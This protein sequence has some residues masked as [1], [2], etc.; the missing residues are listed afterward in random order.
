MAVLKSRIG[1]ALLLD[2]PGDQHKGGHGVL[3]TD[4][5]MASTTLLKKG[6]CPFEGGHRI[7]FRD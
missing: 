4:S 2:P 5:I 3:H 6:L 7:L 1:G